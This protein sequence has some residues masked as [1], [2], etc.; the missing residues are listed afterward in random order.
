[1]ISDRIVFK[2]FSLRFCFISDSVTFICLKVKDYDHSTIISNIF[3]L[4][5]VLEGWV[6]IKPSVVKLPKHKK[7]DR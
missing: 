3:R 5:M 1:M 2:N 7:W 4:Q 6:F